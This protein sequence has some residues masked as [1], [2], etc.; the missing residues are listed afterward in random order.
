MKKTT[1]F[2]AKA[3]IFLAKFFA[4]YSIGQALL[5][6]APLGRL[7]ESIAAWEAA[8]LGIPAAGKILFVGGGSLEIGANCTGL[9]SG[10]ILAAI[11]F[12]LRKPNLKKK[13]EI[14]AIGAAGLF[15]LNLLRVYIVL[16]AGVLWGA[17]A[18]ETAHVVS[19]FAVAGMVLLFWHFL[20]KRIGG[21]GNFGKLL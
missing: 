20:T 8:A 14:T 9:M 10:L 17:P 6:A 1:D 3:A 2:R 15:L 12:S 21:A 11:V 18:G 5:L 16:L 19:W 7:E 4:I 13:A